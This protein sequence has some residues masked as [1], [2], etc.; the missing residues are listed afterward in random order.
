MAVFTKTQA[1]KLVELDEFYM[2]MLD[3]LKKEG[4][5]DDTTHRRY[6]LCGYYRLVE[7]LQE[8]KLITTRQ[9]EEA[10]KGGFTSLVMSLAS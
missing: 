7:F 2:P 8:K 5:L 1:K 4:V 10:M 3:A 9:A 6:M